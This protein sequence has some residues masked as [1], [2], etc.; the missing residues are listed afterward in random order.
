M[1]FCLAGVLTACSVD[2]LSVGLP[3]TANDEE[4]VQTLVKEFPPGEAAQYQLPFRISG[5]IPPYTASIEDCPDWVT[6]FPD[7]GLLAGMAPTSAR[8]QTFFC[9]YTVTDSDTLFTGPQTVSFGLRLEVEGLG[10][11]AFRSDPDRPLPETLDLQVNSFASF[12]LPALMGGVPPYTY[13]VTCAGGNLPPGM[14]F[15]AATRTFAGTPTAAFRDSCAYTATDSSQPADTASHPFEVIVEGP[16]D[17]AFQSAPP[18]PTTGSRLE[19]L[20]VNTFASFPLPALMGGVPPYT[21]AVTC[22]GGALPPGMGFE[23]ATRTFAGT[24]TE[25]FR[26]SC[27]YTATDSS[28]PAVTKSHSFE[29]TVAGPGDLAFQS[30]PPLPTTGSRLEQLRVNTFASFPLPALMGG[31]PP[32]T[33][34]VTCAGG[35]LPPGMGFEAATRTFAGTPTEAFRDSCAYTATDSSQPAVT[36]SH[37]F[38]VTVA[39]PGDL[40][41]QSAPPLPT[42]GSR[43]EQLRVNTFASFPLPALMGGVPPYTYAVTCAGGALPPG[44]GFE[45]ATRTFAGTP[46]EAF[47]DS[48]AYTA[49]DSSQ[50]AVTKSHSFEVTVTPLEQGDTWRFRTRTIA[51]NLHPV[52]RTLEDP[53][54]FVTLPHA[55][56]QLDDEIR[57]EV[58]MYDFLPTAEPPLDFHEDERQLSYTHPGA[59]PVFNTPTTYRYR[60]YLDSWK[61]SQDEECIRRADPPPTEHQVCKVVQD[62]LCVDVSF[63]DEDPMENDQTDGLLSSVSVWIRDDAFLDDTSEEYRCPDTVRSARSSSGATTSNPVH[64]ALAPVHARRVVDV[65]HA[66]VRERV[67]G[68]SPEGADGWTLSP[69]VD[70]AALSGQSGG[71]DYSGSS[72]SLRVGAEAGTGTWQTGLVA[73]FTETELRYRAEADLARLGYRSGEHDT[74]MVSL[75]PFVAWHAPSGGHL[76]MSVGAGLGEL[77]HRDAPDF[78]SVSSSDVRLQAYGLEGTVPL[79]D[80]L[81]GTL[82]AEAGIESFAFDIE[83]GGQISAALSSL[84]GHDYR[85]GLAWSSPVPGTPS[86]SLAY[87]Q[88]TGDGPEGALVE[89][90]GSVSSVGLLNSRL[91]LKGTVTASLGLGDH[92][93]DSL[94]LGA[95]A[96]FAPDRTGRGFGLSLDTRLVSSADRHPAGLGVQGEAGYR[97]W[98]GPVFGM[99]RPYAGLS[100]YPGHVST[101]RMIGFDLLDTPSSKINVEVYDHDRHPASGLSLNLQ[102]RF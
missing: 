87:K 92:E 33:Y 41:F 18:L 52:D 24:P 99:V 78:P 68:W 13:A 73:A 14:G 48:C 70:V 11:L 53:Q 50:P 47:R 9:Q 46:T 32:Y 35:A 39:G 51:R 74:G 59:D 77:R 28:Q 22:A 79:A 3:P 69:S 17:L 6:L 83:G 86:V 81:S 54:K 90:Q 30:A 26:D 84:R 66:G 60:A 42:T 34:A 57:D 49:T 55:I 95:S 10:D 12:P 31:V 62:V 85:A 23:A 88:L 58:V 71:F 40:A 21:Y 5:G 82:D 98:G 93:Q 101:R 38:E 96:R 91:R 65:A 102:H 36:K 44:M 89:A 29:V 7:Q 100:A 1:P 45:A 61:T 64:S 2:E 76:W 63:H 97:L 75:H 20:R 19:Q 67:R 25:A 80:V 94:G 43:L 72:R 37:S 27:A 16:G 15:E 8:G 4:N 56:P